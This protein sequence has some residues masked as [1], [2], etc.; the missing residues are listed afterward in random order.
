MHQPDVRPATRGDVPRVVRTLVRAFADYPF[1]RHTIS[2][3]DHVRRLERF[4]EL[5]VSR[6]GLE[7]GRVW[8]A[9][10]GDAVAVWTTPD[11]AGA[12]DVFADLGPEFAEIAGDRAKASEEAEAAMA[13]H[14]PTDPVWFLGSVGVEPDRQGE[15]LGA[16]V[17]RPGVD[18]ADRAGVPCFLETSDERN[19]RFYRRLGFEV[20]AEYTL[21]GGGPRTWAMRR[22][23]GG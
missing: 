18:E 3:D 15:G 1:T 12:G 9:D 23:A 11:T 4:N 17:I 5:F 10:D 13:P 20:T 14:R 16:A 21:P 6:I 8:V 22:H 2:A 19:V 7:H